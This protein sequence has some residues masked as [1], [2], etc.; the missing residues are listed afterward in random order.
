MW[1]LWQ[2]KDTSTPETDQPKTPKQERMMSLILT[3]KEQIPLPPMVDLMVSK[4]ALSGLFHQ[5]DDERID[6]I[7]A[8]LKEV[9]A[10]VED[11]GE[12]P[13]VDIN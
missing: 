13:H 10:Y 12:A 5:L 1:N 7:V 6:N 4:Q 2:N 11:G 9:I 3:L 8:Q